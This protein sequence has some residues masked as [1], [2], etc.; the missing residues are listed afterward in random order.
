MSR[1]SLHRAG[2]W[3]VGRGG[4]RG[5]K[6]AEMHSGRGLSEREGQERG[7]SVSMRCLLEEVVRQCHWDT[8]GVERQEGEVLCVSFSD[9]AR[10]Y[11]KVRSQ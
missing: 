6:S 5:G 9:I 8:Y 1:A 11:A 7:A 3:D 10:V 2:V 4:D